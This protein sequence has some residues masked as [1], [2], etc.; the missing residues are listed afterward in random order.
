M[1]YEQLCY[2]ANMGS[3]VIIIGKEGSNVKCNIEFKQIVNCRKCASMLIY[4][5]D[6]VQVCNSALNLKISVRGSALVKLF[7]QPRLQKS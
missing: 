4:N 6:S 5:Y 1:L 2:Y 7:L 3:I